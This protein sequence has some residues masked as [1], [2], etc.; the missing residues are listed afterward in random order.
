MPWSTRKGCRCASS[1]IQ[2]PFQDSDG[3]ALVIDKIRSR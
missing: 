3:A 1:S 2:P